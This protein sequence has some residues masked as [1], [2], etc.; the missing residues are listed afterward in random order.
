MFKC[1]C[2]HISIMQMYIDLQSIQQSSLAKGGKFGG[3]FSQI[4]LAS[5]PGVI[6]KS[7]DDVGKAGTIELSEASVNGDKKG[8][9]RFYGCSMMFLEGIRNQER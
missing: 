1:V 8:D 7:I 3:I 6:C 9:V 5:T 2:C 4:N